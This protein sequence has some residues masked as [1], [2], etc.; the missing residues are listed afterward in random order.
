MERS[1]GGSVTVD[2]GVGTQEGSAASEELAGTFDALCAQYWLPVYRTVYRSCQSRGEAEELT[3]EVFA[4]ALAARQQSSTAFE[5][6][7]AYLI[8]IARNL[9]IDR[10]RA[11]QSAPAVRPL[12]WDTPSS[13]NGPEGLIVA[14]QER[15][16]LL[17]ALDALPDRYHEVLRLRLQEEKSP[18]EVGALMNLTPNAVRQLQ[19][20]AVQALRAELGR[21]TEGSTWLT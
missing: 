14:E 15:L 10:W 21:L 1:G 5:V 6:S 9:A 7:G 18:T 4:R 16:T 3:Q 8:Q 19:F 20:R 12:E 17:A 2:D 13:E 11:V